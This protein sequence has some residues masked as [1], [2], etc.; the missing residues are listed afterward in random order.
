MPYS[1]ALLYGI[2]VDF[3]GYSHSSTCTMQIYEIP[4]HIIYLRQVSQDTHS[5]THT[6]GLKYGG[7]NK[8]ENVKT[9]AWPGIYVT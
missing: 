6:M 1:N 5:H 2:E 7:K 4:I 8:Q 3:C 9:A